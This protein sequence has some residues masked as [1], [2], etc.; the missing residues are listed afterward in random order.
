MVD[1]II[2]FIS[3]PFFYYA[4]ML[5]MQLFRLRSPDLRLEWRTCSLRQHC[6]LCW[7][8]CW[9]TH[10]SWVAF[11]FTFLP[12]QW[13][14]NYMIVVFYGHIHTY[15]KFANRRTP[16]RIL[17]SI[18]IF[19]TNIILVAIACYNYGNN[20]KWWSLQKYEFY[21]SGCANHS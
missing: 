19:N 20:S 3:F 18:L 16:S 5:D 11:S 8:L 1:F 2:I 13:V 9:N 7:N 17:Y 15:R 14:S 4:A 6:E 10:H 21:C 12:S